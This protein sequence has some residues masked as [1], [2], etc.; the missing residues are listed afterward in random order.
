[1]TA[2]AKH[3]VSVS[4]HFRSGERMRILARGLPLRVAIPHAYGHTTLEVGESERGPA[5]TTV[6]GAQERKER[7]ILIDRQELP[8]AER[9]ALGRKAK[10]EECKLSNEGIHKE[11][12]YY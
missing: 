2:G 5:I 7:L 9:P 12:R 10:G 3:L 1:M 11:V 8:I 6:S 4:R